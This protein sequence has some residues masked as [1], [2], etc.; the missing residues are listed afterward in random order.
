MDSNITLTN[1][2]TRSDIFKDDEF[3][4]LPWI[5][6]IISLIFATVSIYL[7]ILLI[8]S[9]LENFSKPSLQRRVVRILLMAPIYCICAFL[10]YLF[11]EQD[12]T[13]ELLR[14]C[15]ESFV[16]YEFFNLL[17]QYLGESEEE[18]YRV[19]ASKAAANLIPP[20]CCFRY[21]PFTSYFIKD[22]RILTLQYIIIRPLTTVIALIASASGGSAARGVMFFINLTNFISTGIA[23]YGLAL[24]YITIKK[25][26][27]EYKPVNKFLSVKFVIFMTFWQAMVI[28]AIVMLH[29]NTDVT[30]WDEKHVGIRIQAFLICIEMFVAALWHR[31]E[32][33]F[34]V[35]DFASMERKATVI[36]AIRF[37]F[38]PSETFHDI[39]TSVGHMFSRLYHVVFRLKLEP[40]RTNNPDMEA[41]LSDTEMD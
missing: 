28:R 40:V 41:I 29:L 27:K 4:S 18:R 6:A 26:I 36:E 14:S 34:G 2:T 35:Q 5:G 19:L 8:K 21:Y 13:F 12:L 24:F 16:I 7:S 17:L 20:L 11:P 10:T 22:M 33:C 38:D 39:F 30:Y 3:N 37:S 25:D 31:T 9:H 23:M 1:N 15:Y 32:P